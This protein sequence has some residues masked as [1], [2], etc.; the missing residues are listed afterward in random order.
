M[1]FIKG[2]GNHMGRFAYVQ[3]YEC[4]GIDNAPANVMPELSAMLAAPIENSR[5]LGSA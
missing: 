3:R 4:S 2:C 1:Q 5:Y